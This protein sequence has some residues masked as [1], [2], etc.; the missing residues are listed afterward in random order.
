MARIA[1]MLSVVLLFLTVSLSSQETLTNDSVVKLVKAGLSEDLITGM[2]NTQPGKYSLG[3]EDIIAL[4]NEGV[5]EKIIA[6]MI[7]KNA[8]EPA[9][10]L[11]EDSPASAPVEP[12]GERTS[13]PSNFVQPTSE[14]DFKRLLMERY[15][16]KT[17][18]TMVAGLLA[19]EYKKAFI[20]GP[21]SA[22]LLW[23]H[24]H[25]SV[26]IPDRKRSNPLKLWGKKTSE[27]DQLDE[28]TYADLDK[29]LNVTS[30]DRG[31]PLKVQKFY[32]M[33][34]RI[35]FNLTTTQLSHLRDVDINKASKETTTTVS[36][37][38]VHQRTSVAGFGLRFRFFFDKEQ[39][40]KATDYQG[41]VNEINKYL[42]PKEEAEQV[43]SA[44]RNIEIEPGIS[45]EAV[46]Q[47]L[48]EPSKTIRVGNQKSL[49][50][51]DMTVI[52]KDGKVVDVKLE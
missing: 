48:G 47:K 50:Y 21:G 44:E 16:G 12:L 51:E 32:I 43:L 3:A 4:K 14:E 41:V 17:V 40:L 36:G 11:G 42:L 37:G 25:D 52:L 2:V 29:G 9:P 35:E 34:D 33:S 10:K 28:R 19:G 38:E 49:K 39:V 22:G 13:A 30:L 15:D 31:E 8:P 23:Y 18:V 27:M 20:V 45:E 5:S 1:T 7:R 24:Y 46:L 6:A 26:P